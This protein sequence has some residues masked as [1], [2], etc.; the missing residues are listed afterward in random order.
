MSETETEAR[1]AFFAAC[2]LGVSELLAGE[3]RE[4]GID[5]ER[6]HPAGVAF[7][8]RLTDGY[9][10]CLFS[11]TASRV[12]VTLASGDAGSSDAFYTFVR[13]IPWEQHLAA[14]GTLA[15]DIVGEAPAWVRHTTFAAQR[16]KDG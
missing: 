3:L 13:G 11:R 6:E 10:A 1:R 7:A 8:G 14:D 12:L 2:P 5:V 16:T 4:L 15:V 9:R